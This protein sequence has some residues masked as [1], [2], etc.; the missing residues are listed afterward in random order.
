MYVCI[1]DATGQPRLLPLDPV[2]GSPD[3]RPRGFARPFKSSRTRSERRP[4][5]PVPVAPCSNDDVLGVED[6]IHGRT[7]VLRSISKKGHHHA[8]G[9]EWWDRDSGSQTEPC[10][11]RDPHAESHSERSPRSRELSEL[12]AKSVV[13]HVWP[14]DVPLTTPGVDRQNHPQSRLLARLRLTDKS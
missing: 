11:Q 3:G 2:T 8:R 4:A 5:L 12:L 6:V 7:A 13:I 10:S 9:D 14:P 1:L